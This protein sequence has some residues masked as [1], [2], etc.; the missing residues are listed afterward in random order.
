MVAV[1][2][3]VLVTLSLSTIH[4][5]WCSKIQTHTLLIHRRAQY[6]H[7]S[8]SFPL[9]AQKPIWWWWFRWQANCEQKVKEAQLWQKRLPSLADDECRSWYF[10]MLTFEEAVER[11]SAHLVPAEGRSSVNMCISSH[12]RSSQVGAQLINSSSSSFHLC[13]YFCSVG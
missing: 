5:F 8:F 12:R 2:V 13:S 1:V 3:E 11:T 7:S 4:F 10:I 6:G 9:F